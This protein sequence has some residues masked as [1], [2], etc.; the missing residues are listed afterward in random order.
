MTLIGSNPLCIRFNKVDGFIRV[1][2][3]TSDLLLFGDEKYDSMY[4]RIRYL[5]GVNS[6]ITYVISD[7]YAKSKL[8]HTVFCL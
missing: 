7:N 6:D 1:Y 4:I 3:G 8:I 5:I 2:D